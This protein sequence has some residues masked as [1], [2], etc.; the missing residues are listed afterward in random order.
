MR[1]FMQNQRQ[2]RKH[3]DGFKDGVQISIDDK[4]QSMSH[5]KEMSKRKAVRNNK[6]VK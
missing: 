6:N 3:H 1:G 4:S 5:G 2:Y